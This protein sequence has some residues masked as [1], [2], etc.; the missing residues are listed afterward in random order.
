MVEMTFRFG[1]QAFKN[2]SSTR[3]LLCG[4]MIHTP[5]TSGLARCPRTHSRVGAASSGFIIR[6]NPD[7]SKI[8]VASGPIG[9]VLRSVSSHREVSALTSRGTAYLTKDTMEE[10]VASEGK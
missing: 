6:L 1:L 3:S 5:W 4:C 9:R 2:S 7:C 10:T 8:A